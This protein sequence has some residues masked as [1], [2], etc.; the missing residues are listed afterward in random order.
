MP[1]TFE[2][3]M[4]TDEH[5]LVKW[6]AFRLSC[7][8]PGRAWLD[9]KRADRGPGRHHGGP[10]SPRSRLVQ[11]VLADLRVGRMD[12]V[13]EVAALAPFVVRLLSTEELARVVRL[14]SE[15]SVEATVS[16]QTQAERTTSGPIAPAR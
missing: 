6:V 1:T 15:N 14:W 5:A 11:L 7:D 4:A 10:V 16:S 12:R 8:C 3:L 2:E 13:A 9:P